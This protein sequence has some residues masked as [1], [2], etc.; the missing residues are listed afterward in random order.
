M[1]A[2]TS[3]WQVGQQAVIN[4]E[5]T[6]TIERVTP[7]GRAIAAGRT[8]NVDGTERTSNHWNSA[9]LHPLT[10]ALQAQID[11]RQRTKAARSALN[12]AVV[13][14]DQWARKSFSS[15]NRYQPPIE[16]VEKA[17]RLAAA[18]LAGLGDGA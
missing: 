12:N 10:P 16:D 15:W 7:A 3:F 17:E 2:Q 14:A 4:G 13:A 1:S 8:F 11:L 18:I 5:Q 6:V 9:I